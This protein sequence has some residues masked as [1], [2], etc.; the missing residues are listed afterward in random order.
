MAHKTGSS[1]SQNGRDSKPK[2]LGFKCFGGQNVKPGNI[3]LKQKGFKFYPGIN[4]KLGKD[5]T[6]FA[7]KIGKIY[8]KNTNN[9]KYINVI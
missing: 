8:I 1:H 6:I 3:I 9:K 5:Y 4:T 7:I 2:Y